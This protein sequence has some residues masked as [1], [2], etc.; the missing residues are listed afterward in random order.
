MAK[1]IKANSN[2]LSKIGT[3]ID[4]LEKAFDGVIAD[5]EAIGTPAV[6]VKHAALGKKDLQYGKSSSVAKSIYKSL[7][8]QK[9]IKEFT[10][11]AC[12]K[13]SIKFRSTKH[14]HAAFLEATLFGDIDRTKDGFVFKGYLFDKFDFKKSKNAK[15]KTT[16]GKFLRKLGNTAK[17]LQNAGVLKPFKIRVDL[18]FDWK[19]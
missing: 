16:Y 9:K 7:E 18:E 3:S 1:K 5:L 19:K 2:A 17:D 4:D 12:I 11:P 15:V 13:A 10:A 14:L 8:F 6:F